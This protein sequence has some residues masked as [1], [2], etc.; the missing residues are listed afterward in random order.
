MPQYKFYFLDERGH[1]FR[2]QDHLLPDDLTAL[3]SAK[4]LCVRNAIEIWQSARQV[5]R[6]EP[7]QRRR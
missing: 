3:E 1:A 4:V 6:V 5:A 2:A 7:E